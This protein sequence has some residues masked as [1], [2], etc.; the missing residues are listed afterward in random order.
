MVSRYEKLSSALSEISRIIQ[1]LSSQEMGE[2]GLKGSFAKYLLVLK[3][4]PDGITATAICDIC[5]RNKADVSRALCEMW[6]LGL[7]ERM[8]KGSYR[9]KLVLTPRGREIADKL[10]TR[11][12]DFI[13]YVGKDI[14]D[15]EREIF[16]RSLESITAN[17]EAIEEGELSPLSR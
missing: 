17:L 10:Q 2:F 12:N 14:D 13:S 5:E 15:N 9:A 4:H 1:K 16:Y 3:R 11:A 6:D 8:G 7:V